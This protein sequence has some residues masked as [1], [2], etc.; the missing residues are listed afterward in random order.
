MKT[1]FKPITGRNVTGRV[2]WSLGE[3]QGTETDFIDFF[4]G[5]EASGGGLNYN[6]DTQVTPVLGELFK[7]HETEIGAAEDYHYIWPNKGETVEQ[8]QA[9]V[10]ERLTTAGAV[11]VPLAEVM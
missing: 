7:D 3:N 11:M 6:Y 10:K 9:V 2:L 8:L 1:Q 5:A 4:C